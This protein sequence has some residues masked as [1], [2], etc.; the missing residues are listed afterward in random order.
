M[1]KNLIFLII[2][3]TLLLYFS[4]AKCIPKKEREE[5]IVFLSPLH[6]YKYMCVLLLAWTTEQGLLRPR[7]RERR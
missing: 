6:I 5:H 3:Y 7:L 4:F 1:V 2:R